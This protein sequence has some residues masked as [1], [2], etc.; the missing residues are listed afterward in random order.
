VKP[1]KKENRAQHFCEE[2]DP[3]QRRVRHASSGRSLVS[4]VLECQLWA[5]YGIKIV[6]SPLDLEKYHEAVLYRMGNGKSTGSAI[7]RKE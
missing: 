5:E 2:R 6:T 1:N 7:E 4:E 3:N